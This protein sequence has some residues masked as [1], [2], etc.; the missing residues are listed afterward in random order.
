MARLVRT[1]IIGYPHQVT[2]RGNYGQPVFEAD[3]DYELYV[4]WAREYAARYSI[5]VWAYCL[6]PNHVHFVCV[7][8]VERALALGFNALNMRYA[9]YFH[10]KKGVT[11]HLWTGRFLSCMLDEQSAKEEIRFI[12]NNPVRLGL[13]ERAEDYLWSS[14]RSHVASAADCLLGVCPSIISEGQD[15]SDFLRGQ[16]NENIISRIRSRL[17][18]G[19]PAGDSEFVKKIEKTLGRRIEALPRGRPKKISCQFHNQ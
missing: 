2:Q 3:F 19:R 17:K 5:Q 7:P 12:E 11:G 10:K 1:T 15:W 18:T 16:G 4:S 13:V 6:M 9:Q 8:K 14:A